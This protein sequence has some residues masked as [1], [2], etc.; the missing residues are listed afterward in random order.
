MNLY[1]LIQLICWT[2]PGLFK[3]VQ[4][5]TVTYT[6]RRVEGGFKKEFKRVTSR[7]WSHRTERLEELISTAISTL[8]LD[9]AFLS[10]QGLLTW[11]PL[12]LYAS[13]YTLQIPL[14]TSHELINAEIELREW[15]EA[16]L[17]PALFKTYFSEN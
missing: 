4:T 14:P 1:R 3:K 17:D 10:K 8:E 13:A 16:E 15:A 11:E 12:D 7:R 9:F 5:V 2:E 6:I